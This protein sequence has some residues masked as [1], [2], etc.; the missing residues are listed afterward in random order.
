MTRQILF[1]TTSGDNNCNVYFT[2]NKLETRRKSA[3]F[4]SKIF[5]PKYNYAVV[6]EGY[7]S[8]SD[9]YRRKRISEISATKKVVVFGYKDEDSATLISKNN[10]K[11]TINRYWFDLIRTKSIS[12]FFVRKGVELL[13]DPQWDSVFKKWISFN[14]FHY[15]KGYDY[16]ENESVIIY[17]Q[18]FKC[19]YE[20][21]EIDDVKYQIEKVFENAIHRAGLKLTLALE[22]ADISKLKTAIHLMLI[23]K[24]NI[25]SN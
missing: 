14:H 19:F 8:M 7:N 9:F 6:S 20:N 17:E 5:E 16:L 15:L 10:P 2:W 21:D 22:K 3:R 12:L 24:N 25:V 11:N 13:R 4:I 23:N 1:F 18:I